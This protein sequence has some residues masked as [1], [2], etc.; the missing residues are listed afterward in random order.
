[1]KKWIRF[2]KDK[3]GFTTKENYVLSHKGEVLTEIL[4]NH[5]IFVDLL[6]EENLCMILLSMS[7]ERESYSD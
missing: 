6:S 2:L 5:I 1:M 3:E 4:D 7:K